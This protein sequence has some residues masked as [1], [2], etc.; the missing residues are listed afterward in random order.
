MTMR[1]LAEVLYQERT[2]STVA[3]VHRL[4]DRLEEKNYVERERAG[5]SYQYR[6]IIARE[7]LI[8]DQLRAT[9]ERFCDGALAPLFSRLIQSRK[10]SQQECD[11]LRS[12]I[13]QLDKERRE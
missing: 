2:P 7:A 11:E 4:L 10:L 8:D 5:R 3:T 13:D 6:A 12:L 9:A 1:E